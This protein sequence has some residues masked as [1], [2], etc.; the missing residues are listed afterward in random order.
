MR[1]DHATVFAII[2]LLLCFTNSSF[3]QAPA[4]V[5]QYSNTEDAA[6]NIMGSLKNG[7]YLFYGSYY[8]N[9]SD[10]YERDLA[11]NKVWSRGVTGT[12]VFGCFEGTQVNDV[13][14]TS[15]SGFIMVMNSSLR[16]GPDKTHDHW[17][18]PC[19]ISDDYW[20]VKLSKT[21]AYQ[22]DRTD[23]TFDEYDMPF[24]VERH[25]GGGYVIAGM[26]AGGATGN[27]TLPNKGGCSGYTTCG[28]YWFVRVDA[29]GN[30]LW[31]KTLGG[32]GDDWLW[33]MKLTSTNQYIICGVSISSASGDK[34]GANF[35]G[36]DFWIMKTDTNMNILWQTTLG[37]TDEEGGYA[38][39]IIQTTDGNFVFV[40]DSKSG[41][42]GPGKKAQASKGDRDY[43]VVKLNAATGDTM[44]TRTIGGALADQ[45]MSLQ[46]TSDGGLV[47]GGTSVS[48]ISGDKT[49]NNRDASL[50][51]SDYW[52]V[53]LSSSGTLLWDKT[54]GTI[55]N[56][57][58]C[59]V[60]QNA[61]GQYVVSGRG[62][63]AES[64]DK[65]VT[66]GSSI[67]ENWIIVLASSN[68]PIEL[69]D[70]TAK[71]QN[72]RSVLTEW[73]TTA[74]VNNDYFVVERSVDGAS[75][76]S[77]GTIK[78][79]GNSSEEHHYSLPDQQPLAGTS[80]YRLRQVD[81]NGSYVYYGPVTVRLEG[82]DI[83][84]IFPNPAA[85]NFDYRVVSSIDDNA[86]YKITDVLGR[87]VLDGTTPIHQGEN[88]LK[89]E[90]SD[91]TPGSYAIQIAVGH[92]A[93][94]AQKQFVVK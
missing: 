24:A 68:L 32:S 81:F 29:N 18:T 92:A 8:T 43:W 33:D 80:Y 20:T 85:D 73:T 42:Y 1:K 11:F 55:G 36:Y 28:D 72:N 12:Q 56:E 86:I 83:V 50:G 23:G 21:G 4:I 40:G 77:V 63:S 79:T 27:K 94:R 91:F 60:F 61:L 39:K 49:E 34:T 38:A 19:D 89:V 46:E 15:D 48:N 5:A 75:W 70:F 37:G 53:K 44:W 66:T 35:G 13:Q 74:E 78:G 76:E 62:N 59:N 54:L 31:E 10:I 71:P 3:S 25:P 88:Q 58:Y 67:L 69:L 2:G 52:V 6:G 93:Y 51:G 82:I 87:T 30:K 7:N 45:A 26:S 41:I 90:L 47:I 64:G 57:D 9:S 22:W 65:T 14:Q 84:N 17:G 16:V